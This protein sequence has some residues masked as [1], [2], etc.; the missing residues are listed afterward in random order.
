MRRTNGKRATIL[1]LEL[2]RHALDVLYLAQHAQRVR[3]DALSRRGQLRESAAPAGEDP[4]T[5]LA[6][7]QLQLLADRRLGRG[8]LGS[9]GSEVQIILN[10]GG[11]EAELL[12]FHWSR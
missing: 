9:R 1:V 2:L 3:D 10:D 12:E 8:Q 4:E 11:E 7:Q 6:F 5:Q